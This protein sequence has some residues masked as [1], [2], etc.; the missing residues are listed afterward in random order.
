MYMLDF[1]SLISWAHSPSTNIYNEGPNA[2]HYV[3][4]CK[5]GAIIEFLVKQYADM[6]VKDNDGNSPCDLCEKNW[7]WLEKCYIVTN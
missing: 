3:A 2:L 5:R 6:D 4:I 1:I 7:S